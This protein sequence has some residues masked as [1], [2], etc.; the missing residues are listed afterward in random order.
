MVKRNEK[1]SLYILAA[2]EQLE[3]NGDTF[4]NDKQLFDAYCQENTQLTS[5]QYQWD[6]STLIRKKL[7]HLEGGRIYLKRTWNYEVAVTNY[8]ADILSNNVTKGVAL[9]D[10]LTC[11]DVTLS[12]QQ[13]E[14]IATALSSRLSMILGSAGSGKTTL[15]QAMVKKAPFP[16]Y[17]VVTAAPTGK[18]ARNLT[19]RTGI[20]ARTIHSALG[21][22]P[23]ENFLDPVYWEYVHLVV[24]DEASM[25]SLEMLAGILNRVSKD[26]RVVLL[27]DPNQLLAV[28]AGN[29]LS[30]L[31]EL[32]VPITYLEQQ[33]RQSESAEAL[34]YNVVEFPNLH[35]ISEFRWDDSFRLIPAS[36]AEIA[37]IVCCEAAKRYLGGESVQ[38]LSMTN[39]K[40]AFSAADLNRGIQ[41][42]VNPLT[43]GALT[44][45]NF[46]NG[47]RMI[48]LK[49]NSE[50]D[51]SN[52]DVGLL[53]LWENTAILPL[54]HRAGIW[55]TEYPPKDLALAYALTVHKSQGSQY[56]TVIL[57][58]STATSKM[59]YRNLLY[60]A[61]SRAKKQVILVGSKEALHLAMQVTPR[62][63]RS[64]LVPRTRMLLFRRSA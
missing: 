20:Q 16:A 46:R 7:L 29:I 53:Q 6:K 52:G 9:P 31:R 10:P 26:C 62:P 3:K 34:R 50:Q 30:D 59:L 14:A 22:I 4:F 2:I 60:T 55:N 27:G 12:S 24:I 51:L 58:V 13:R 32:G 25:V 63:R 5:E 42:L 49:N 38:V 44:W 1:S 15:I 18:A 41:D 54:G 28:G 61:I 57:P 19:E 37:K 56:D 43:K 33:Y 64:M 21:K 45:G 35:D 39:H 40:T 48:V 11:G 8:L 23:D 36:D 17:T 47:D